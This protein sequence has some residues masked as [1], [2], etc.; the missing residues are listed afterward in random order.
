MSPIKPISNPSVCK[1]GEF[2]TCIKYSVNICINSDIFTQQINNG[3]P[4]Q[5]VQKSTFLMQRN[6]NTEE[7]V[8]NAKEAT[9]EILPS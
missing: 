6:N 4:D 8:K 5:T 3:V 1:S 7:K 9:I 2:S